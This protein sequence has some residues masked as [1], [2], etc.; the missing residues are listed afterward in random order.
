MNI[1]CSI[2]AS[3]LTSKWIGD[4]EKMVRALFAVARVHQPAV[5]FI[6][7]VDSLLTQ[8]SETE[9]ESSRRLKT[10][11]LVELDGAA[12]DAEERLLIIGATNRPQELDE[13]ARRRF[14]KRLY[15]PLPECEARLQLV[16]RLICEEKHCLT[17]GDCK[18]VAQLSDGYSGA[19][20][21]N[22]C[23]EAALG[24]IRNLDPSLMEH[25]RAEDVRPLAIEDFLNAFRRIRS[26]VAPK[27]LDQYVLWDSTYGSG[28]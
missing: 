28:L 6:D 26:S 23:S 1:I 22:L 16:K 18:E 7:E 12:T 27:D 20:I 17:E 2:S 24:P 19:D 8:R 11:F 14:T 10:E 21:R 5:I 13:A 4:G 9:H 15:I 25:I 3:S